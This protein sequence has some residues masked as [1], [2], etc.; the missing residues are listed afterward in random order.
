MTLIP[1]VD[2]LRLRMLEPL[3]GPEVQLSLLTSQSAAQYKARLKSKE[4]IAQS[5]ESK[6]SSVLILLYEKE[7]QLFVPLIQRPQYEGVHSGQVSLPGGKVEPH[8]EDVVATALREAYEEIGIASNQVKVLGLLTPVFIPPSRFW[9]HVVL[10]YME[11]VPQFV[12]DAYEVAS[13]I[14]LPLHHLEDEAAVEERKLDM[15]NAWSQKVSGYRY[16]E[17]FIWGATSMI[18]TEL[19]HLMKS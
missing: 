10:G 7:G 18:L 6:Q 19:R 8:D 17:Y 11:E 12:P 4:E 14:E 1:L 16:E 13:V 9:V 3:P 2:R 5:T 15:A